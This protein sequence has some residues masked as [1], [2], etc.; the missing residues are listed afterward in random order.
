MG[1]ERFIAVKGEWKGI[2]GEVF[3]VY[4][5]GPHITRQKTSLWERLT[6]LTDRMG[7]A[8]CIFGDL[9]VVRCN[10]DRLNS[11]V[12][13][14]EMREFNDFIND[15]GSWKFQWVDVDLDFGPKPFRAFDIWLE[16]SD[17][18]LIVE[19]AWK[20]EVRSNRPDCRFWDKLKNVKES[21]K[22]ERF[23]GSR[24]KI[25]MYNKEAM[26]WE[27]EA[28]NRTLA[29]NERLA[30]MEARKRW[31]E[32]E[33]EC[34]NMLRQKARIKWD[35]EDGV[36]CEDPK[37]IKMEMARHYKA[38][39]MNRTKVQPIFCC[40]RIG[41]ITKEEARDLEKDFNKNEVLEA[42]RGCGG[43]KAPGPD[44]F[45][46]KFIRKFWNVIKP[47][48]LE[49]VRWFWDRMEILRGCNSSFISI[50]PKVADP[51]GLGDFRSISLIGCYYKIIAKML[52]ERIKKVVGTLVGDVQNAFIK[53]RYILDEVLIA[54]ETME[55]LKKKKEKGLIFK[56]DFAKAYD[57]IN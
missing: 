9:N 32:K 36:W 52:A 21:L 47:D 17:F 8:W 16:E 42:I 35:V 46:F 19:D 14:K 51:I 33:N 26:R 41:K 50:I 34:N 48:L 57:N 54:N 40:E 22:K 5:Y 10:D 45:N 13:V 2:N 56:V 43:D 20:K 27:L 15:R 55:F 18:I 1:D 11:Q 3:L 49:A 29:E 28:E 23:G 39:F 25:E 24:E 53:G 12:N 31:E 6:G 38:L 4:V 30:W 44:G 37:K 7:G